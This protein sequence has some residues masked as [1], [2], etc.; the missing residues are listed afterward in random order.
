[1]LL[2]CLSGAAPA[3]HNCTLPAVA[4][5]ASPLGHWEIVDDSGFGE[6][7][8]HGGHLGVDLVAPPGT[9]V[10]A[11]REGVVVRAVRASMRWRNDLGKPDVPEGKGRYFGTNVVIRHEGGVYTLYGHLSGLKAHAGQHVRAGEV[12]GLSGNTGSSSGPHLHFAVADSD[13]FWGYAY[14]DFH[15]AC[16]EYRGVTYFDPVRMLAH[17]TH[18]K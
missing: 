5:L 9:L 15:A 17:G 3:A 16:C 13:Q 11:A 4:G 12:I 14:H 18:G 10:H 2:G 6:G 7:G 1:M 8:L